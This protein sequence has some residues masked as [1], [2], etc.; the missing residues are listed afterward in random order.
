MAE[1]VAGN[2]YLEAGLERLAYRLE[3]QGFCGTQ[4]E[5]IL[6]AVRAHWPESGRP[7][8]LAQILQN[9]RPACG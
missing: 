8:W 6:D 2:E 9:I 3:R 4:I 1:D 5:A 7:G